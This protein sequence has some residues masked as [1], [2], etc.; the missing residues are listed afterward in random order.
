M[1]IVCFIDDTRHSILLTNIDKAEVTRNIIPGSNC[2]RRK[3]LLE[4]WSISTWFTI[5]PGV[6]DH[7]L[8]VTD[9]PDLVIVWTPL[10]SNPLSLL[11]HEKQKMICFFIFNLGKASLIKYNLDR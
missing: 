8:G 4:T 6:V 11:G 10:P 7:W 3:V 1:R 2:V 9:S 5:V